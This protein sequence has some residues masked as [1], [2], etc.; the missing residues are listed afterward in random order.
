MHTFSLC[1]PG[2]QIEQKSHHMMLHQ[3]THL[4]LPTPMAQCDITV[5]LSP[6]H[7]HEAEIVLKLQLLSFQNP[8]CQR[9]IL[10]RLD[11]PSLRVLQKITLYSFSKSFMEYNPPRAKSFKSFILKSVTP[12][13]FLLFAM[14][15]FS[16]S[17]VIPLAKTC[18]PFFLR[19]DLTP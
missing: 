12:N 19:D 17:L 9:H 2:G 5:F 7:E 4:H 13:I 11:L 3:F 1:Q 18:G 6:A 10:S 8:C 16:S 15:K 14:F